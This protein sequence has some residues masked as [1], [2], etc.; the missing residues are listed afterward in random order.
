[1]SSQPA[2]RN[3]LP[4]DLDQ[5]SSVLD[6][7]K[8][9]LRTTAD[10]NLIQEESGDW[11]VLEEPPHNL[12][13]RIIALKKDKGAAKGPAKGPAIGLPESK[14]G[15]N[16]L[17]NPRTSAPMARILRNRLSKSI[18]KLDD[19]AKLDLLAKKKLRSEIIIQQYQPIGTTDLKVLEKIRENYGLRISQ[20]L[21]GDWFKRSLLDGEFLQQVLGKA[22]AMNDE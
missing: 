18:R 2:K 19:K 3:R 4:A 17:D 14:N 20:C 7:T 5:Y 22:L 10:G 21:G 15:A 16:G 9:P 12:E 1:M 6:H 8:G 13:D 11:L